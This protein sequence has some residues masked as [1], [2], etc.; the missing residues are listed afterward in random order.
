MNT[1]TVIAPAI[2]LTV[3]VADSVHI[4]VVMLERM[5][6][7]VG[8]FESILHSYR[9]NFAPVLLTSFTTTLGYLALNFTAAPP[10]RDL[11]I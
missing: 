5:R 4:L 3:S 10:I 1:S 2:I 6:A 7:G 9:V 8:R 11:G